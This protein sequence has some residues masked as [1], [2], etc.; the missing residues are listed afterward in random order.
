MVMNM[1]EALAILTFA[2]GMFGTYTI[3][4]LINRYKVNN[5]KRINDN[6]RDSN[7]IT[8]STVKQ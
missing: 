3:L 4:D 6:R 2:L 1:I 7:V 5:S 8:V